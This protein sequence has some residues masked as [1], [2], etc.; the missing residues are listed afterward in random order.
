MKAKAHKP[1]Y[2]MS[3]SPK[4]IRPGGYVVCDM[5]GPYSVETLSGQ[6][7]VL[8]YT[9]W[10]TRYSWTYI[11]TNKNEAL[12]KLKH[13]VEVVFKASRRELGHYHSDQAGELQ[14][15][16]TL[17]Y[18]DRI[19]HATHSESEAYTPAR[20]GIAERKFR[21]LAE[22]TAAMLFDS[23]L[24]KS[25]WGYAYE[26]ATHIRN[27]IPTVILKGQSMAKSLYELWHDRVPNIH[28]IR[29]W[30]CKCFVL[31]PKQL[32]T[33]IFQTKSEW[34]SSLVLLMKAPI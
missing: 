6:R 19:V 28:Y 14:G 2:Y 18:L 30:G 8:T 4:A 15:S 26:A 3:T 13:L 32:R 9:D 27:R 25:Y 23:G 22:M 1:S 7:Y 34:V 24:P 31:I 10:Y 21:T 33:K 17:N 20:N 12:P 5:Q 29:R 16:E 11:L